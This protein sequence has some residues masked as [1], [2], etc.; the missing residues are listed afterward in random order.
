MQI[1]IITFVVYKL[2]A[3][4]IS[5]RKCY[6]Y[7]LCVPCL[8]YVCVMC[9]LCVG[10]EKRSQPAVAA[11][12]SP[13]LVVEAA[14]S[15]LL[16]DPTSSTMPSPPGNNAKRPGPSPAPTGEERAKQALYSGTGI[17]R[18]RRMMHFA[19]SAVAAMTKSVF[20]DAPSPHLSH[21]S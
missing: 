10:W 12:G 19:Y 17:S 9:V 7:V 13:C 4:V 15:S 16:G 3:C 14:S 21:P 18:A 6:V 11:G 2:S 20:E 8:C 5:T 1:P